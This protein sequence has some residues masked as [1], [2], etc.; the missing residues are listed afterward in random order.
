M[1]S[2]FLDAAGL[3]AFYSKLKVWIAG[4]YATIANL[5]LKVDKIEGKG[6]SKNDFTDALKSKL[7]GIQTYQ[8]ATSSAPGVSGL[9][10]SAPAADRNKFLKGDG[11]WS[12]V[13]TE[14][15]IVIADEEPTASSAASYPA[16]TVFV[17]MEE[18]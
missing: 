2:K 12:E 3:A 6:L 18:D 11:T 5:D 1:P 17:L 10:P 16:G 8:G 9:V 4:K 7:D 14:R 15:E 13:Q